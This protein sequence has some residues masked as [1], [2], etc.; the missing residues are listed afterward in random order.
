MKR[1]MNPQPRSM[2]FPRRVL[3]SRWPRFLAM[4][5]QTV[6]LAA[7]I[8]ERCSSRPGAAFGNCK[9]RC[10][11]NQSGRSRRVSRPT[12][13]YD[14]GMAPIL[15][16]RDWRAGS[17]GECFTETFSPIMI[18][19]D[20]RSDTLPCFSSFRDA[21]DFQCRCA[22]RIHAKFIVVETQPRSENS[23]LA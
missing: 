3:C 4:K 22:R 14:R 9:L 13:H 5:P 19:A 11:A 1:L 21:S 10:Q 6:L 2:C 17:I 16:L 23:R 12:D 18:N 8:F 15:A 7:M 20:K